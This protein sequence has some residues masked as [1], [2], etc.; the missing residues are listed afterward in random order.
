MAV[1]HREPALEVQVESLVRELRKM[2]DQAQ[3]SVASTINSTLSLL[4][5][6]LG[7]RIY[8][9][10]L[11]KERAEY[12][13]AIVATIDGTIW[14]GIYRKRIAKDDPICTDIS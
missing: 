1:Q 13:R 11:N 9:E 12:G 3:A 8:R 7:D 2:I 10:I 14:Q 5:W 4:N 6:H